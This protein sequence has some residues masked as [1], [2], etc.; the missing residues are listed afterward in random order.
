MERMGVARSTGEELSHTKHFGAYFHF[1]RRHRQ[2]GQDPQKGAASHHGG[3]QWPVPRHSPSP[4][5]ELSEAPGFPTESFPENKSHKPSWQSTGCREV[6]RWCQASPHSRVPCLD[7]THSPM[8]WRAPFPPSARAS[9]SHNIQP[10]DTG[11]GTL[12]L[13]LA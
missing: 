6:L 12:H 4:K 8:G 13:S 10:Q 11:N 1:L 7:I 9:F 2:L 5:T 3:A